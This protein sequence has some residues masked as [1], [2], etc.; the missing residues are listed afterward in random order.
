MNS[1]MGN[2]LKKGF[3]DVTYNPEAEKAR[4][5]NRER[6]RPARNDLETLYEQDNNAYKALKNEGPRRWY[7]Y[8]VGKQ[9]KDLRTYLDTNPDASFDDL[10]DYKSKYERQSEIL[11]EALSTQIVYGDQGYL[12]IVEDNLK[13]DILEKKITQKQSDDFLKVYRDMFSY[14]SKINDNPSKYSAET[15]KGKYDS[16]IANIDTIKGG[17]TNIDIADPKE[18]PPS[19]QDI[20]QAEKNL[21]K[22]ES[23]VNSVFDVKR[24]FKTI[25]SVST[26]TIVKGLIVVFFLVSGMLASND[27]IGR[28]VPYRIL[29]FIYGGLYFPILIP[30]YTVKFIMWIMG[31]GTV[32]RIYKLLPIWDTESDTSLGRF[33]LFPFTYESDQ[34]EVEA[35][36]AFMKSLEEFVAEPK[37][38][39]G[40]EGEAATSAD[41][42][43]KLKN[44]LSRE[45]ALQINN[46]A[47]RSRANSATALNSIL[48]KEKALQLNGS[49]SEKLEGI[50]KSLQELPVKNDK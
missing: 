21:K 16:F 14:I 27:A 26:N 6:A 11:K 30:Y 19:E 40:K 35:K 37:G 17:A 8:Y 46:S 24:M 33:F 41:T 1:R 18:G 31:K 50:L 44:I 32:P 9:L 15:Y 20:K 22:T 47:S 43:A 7:Y 12:K 48:S 13:K 28:E 23:Q 4:Q 49:T 36:K 42:D 3:E 5:E 25:F 34:N 39:K 29:Y 45:Q 38:G 10:V 2:T